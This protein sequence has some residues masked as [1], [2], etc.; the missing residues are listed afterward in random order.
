MNTE[1]L[2][3]KKKNDYIINY[4]NIAKYAFIANLFFAFLWTLSGFVITTDEYNSDVG[5]TIIFIFLLLCLIFLILTIIKGVKVKKSK[6]INYF[7]EEEKEAYL[8]KFLLNQIAYAS[9]IFFGILIML[10]GLIVRHDLGIQI[11]SIGIAITGIGISICIYNRIIRK[12]YLSKKSNV[13]N[14]S[15]KENGLYHSTPIVDRLIIL[16]LFITNGIMLYR[17]IVKY[18]STLNKVLLLVSYLI[19]MFYYIFNQIK[20]Y[21]KLKINSI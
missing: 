15:I 9:I 21:R 13:V 17:Y 3:D 5:P 4:K 18:E 7:S 11:A 14:D 1:N 8:Q 10:I 12:M 20:C 19:L 16:I 2:F 6:K